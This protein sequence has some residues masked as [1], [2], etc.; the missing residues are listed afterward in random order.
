LFNPL[1]DFFSCLKLKNSRQCFSIH[2]ENPESLLTNIILVNM[3]SFQ[4][5]P[6]K[7][8]I[9]YLSSP[10]VMPTNHYPLPLRSKTTISDLEQVGRNPIRSKPKSEENWIMVYTTPRMQQ[11]L[12]TVN[13]LF[14]HI[15]ISKLE[16]GMFDLAWSKMVKTIFFR[17]F[18]SFFRYR[19]LWG[20]CWFMWNLENSLTIFFWTTK[21]WPLKERIH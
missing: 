21:A 7:P 15:T 1:I 10:S 13:V 2:S 11:N 4:N 17:L 18:K 8:E 19:F 3:S 6:C 14:S 9:L 16:F 20:L 5:N 12:E